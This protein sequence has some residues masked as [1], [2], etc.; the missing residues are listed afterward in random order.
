MYDVKLEVSNSAGYGGYGPAG[1]PVAIRSHAM[2]RFVIFKLN[3]LIRVDL[4]SAL[5]SAIIL[6]TSSHHIRL[7]FL[8]TPLYYILHLI[9]MQE[10]R[11]SR[12]PSKKIRS[13]TA[14]APSQ[15]WDSSIQRSKPSQSFLLR[16][17]KGRA[18]R[19]TPFSKNKKRKANKARQGQSEES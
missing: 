10:P 19:C 15:S 3:V 1:A 14:A 9:I 6:L 12:A 17:V 11:D 8:G 16:K 7:A 4:L 13:L 18:C 2:G 5:R